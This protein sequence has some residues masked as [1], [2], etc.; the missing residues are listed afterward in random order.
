MHLNQTI[1]VNITSD[2]NFDIVNSLWYTVV[3][4]PK[5]IMSFQSS[6]NNKFWDIIKNYFLLPYRSVKDKKEK[7]WENVMNRKGKEKNS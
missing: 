5:C 2:R 7:D 1:K 6:E 3:F 4:F